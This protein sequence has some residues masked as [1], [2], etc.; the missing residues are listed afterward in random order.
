[1]KPLG[2]QY[3]IHQQW[4]SETSDD[5]Q[6]YHLEYTENLKS[7]KELRDQRL[8]V[9]II[10]RANSGIWTIIESRAPGGGPTTPVSQRASDGPA[11]VRG[12]GEAL[13]VY[14]R[15]SDA[16]FFPGSGNFPKFP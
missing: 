8:H 3:L 6:W 10:S 2:I 15:T 11:R 5:L 14:A 4:T 7:I 9:E 12:Q 16:E 13:M 1:M